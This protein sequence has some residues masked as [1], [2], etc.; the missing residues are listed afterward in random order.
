M[1]VRLFRDSVV[2]TFSPFFLLELNS[3]IVWIP[4]VPYIWEI[5]G[6][7]IDLAIT[8]DEK[9]IFFLSHELM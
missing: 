5:P 8:L 1:T 2:M 9:I 6:S 7:D 3:T 4:L